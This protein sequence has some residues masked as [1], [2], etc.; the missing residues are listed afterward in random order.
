M[1]GTIDLGNG[2]NIR[3]VTVKGEEGNGYLIS[4]PAA[5]ECPFPYDG[6]CGGYVRTRDLGDGK[7]VWTV[8]QEDP[9][10]LSPSIACG[11]GG[12]HG[13]VTEGRYV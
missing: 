2:W 7:A 1:S 10:T 11:C 6:R 5:P 3:P 8:V 4:G 9:L 12:Q 13:H